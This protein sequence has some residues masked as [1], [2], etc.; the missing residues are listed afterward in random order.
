MGQQA[1]TIPSTGGAVSRG[2]LTS[3][4]LLAV[5]GSGVVA[6]AFLAR[7]FGRNAATDGF[8]A[9]YGVYLVLA[10]AAQSFRTLVIPELTRAEA[11][12]ALRRE[13]GGYALTFA[14]SALALAALVVALADPLGRLLTGSLPPDA[15]RT[16]AA[17]LVWLVPAALLQLFAGLF[18]SALAATGSYAPPAAGYA[19]G[20]VAGLVL[21]VAL[22]GHGL[23]SLAW[24]TVLN[25]ALAAVIPLAVLIARR[26]SPRPAKGDTRPLSRLG[27]LL[28]GASVPLAAQ[29]LYLLCLRS[30]A[31]L[32]IGTTSS[33]SY[34]YL[35]VAVMVATTAGSLSLVSAQ[36]FT[37]ASRAEQHVNSHVAL[38]SWLC[39]L[40]IA[41]GTGVLAM[42]GE[43]LF[44]LALGVGYGGA[45]GRELGLMVLA[46]A[47]WGAVATLYTLLYP[48]VFVFRR[49]QRLPLLALAA[50]VLHG[51]LLIALH[52][53]GFL[54]IALALAV[55]TLVLAIGLAWT[56]DRSVVA[57]TLAS[58]AKVAILSALLGTVAFAPWSLL[59]NPVL[60]AFG[61]FVTMALLLVAWRPRSL[62]AAWTYAL[63]L[64]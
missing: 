26:G 37:G 27:L 19:I 31:D 64:R 29:L 36:P 56:I 47:P 39:F 24:G 40:P 8:L 38:L 42:A 2:L 4:S 12:G 51:L 35:L 18:S 62:R 15:A 5:S 48:L 32:A 49:A 53:A 46:L 13:V 52:G 16:A 7:T 20:A 30:T 6:A 59:P 50:L 41:A 22:I 14:V 45:T 44:G 61:G 23:V 9:A 43:S 55:S 1:P 57:G 58:V 21:F 25:G 63:S 34:A 54:A 3:I 60:R 10:L 17:A 28:A 33:F 11:A